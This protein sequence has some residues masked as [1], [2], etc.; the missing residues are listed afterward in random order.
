MKNEQT[1]EETWQVM[2]NS[3]IANGHGDF[4]T[5][6]QSDRTEELDMANYDYESSAEG[7]G[8]AE[9][10]TKHGRRRR[11][12]SQQAVSYFVDIS[13]EIDTS[14]NG[15]YNFE[16]KRL[17]KINFAPTSADLDSS[18]SFKSIGSN[19]RVLGRTQRPIEVDDP[20]RKMKL[21]F[22][23]KFSFRK[24]WKIS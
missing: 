22:S 4:N 21:V 1:V 6:P 12:T 3:V 13:D 14:Y 5:A 19:P 11:D 9:E 2:M 15:S 18:S 8:V 7:S 17:D 16:E 24:Y 20:G 10:L 23:D